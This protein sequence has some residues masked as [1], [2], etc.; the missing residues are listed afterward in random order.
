VKRPADRVAGWDLL[1][2]LCAL[3]VA[4]YHLL[5]WMH[6]AELPALGTYGVYM[7]F[8][9]SGASLAYNYSARD[10][11]SLADAL[12][13]LRTRWLRLA[14]LYVLLS[15]LFLL[16]LAPRLAG[17]SWA[18]VANR[19][20]WNATFAFGLRDPATSAI[21]I[22]GWSLGIEFIYYLC[23]PALVYVVPRVRWAIA[24]W[25][26]LAVLQ[27]A[28]IRLTIGTLGWSEGVVGYHQVPAFAAYFFGGCVIGNLR[29]TQRGERAF[30]WGVVA[31]LAMALLLFAL[32]PQEPGDELLGAS[33]YLLFAACFAVVLA[34]GSIAVQ[35][36]L[37]QFSSW[38][39]DITYGT[40]LMHPMIFWTI[41]WFVLPGLTELPLPL[42][43]L[44]LLAVVSSAAILA[45]CSERWFER[46]LRRLGRGRS[47]YIE[48]A[49]ISS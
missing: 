31:W 16:M 42:R 19:L 43:V 9:L 44:I 10:F 39:G 14:P 3:T 45:Y 26:L 32:M 28:W 2:G 36:R 21:L 34:S 17:W 49:S 1:R 27:F 20:A 48:A 7:F 24:V 12:R 46:P 18:D 11:T 13:F 22:G 5:Y 33:G 41:A 37:A 40:Y 4:T 38:M 29:R 15:L 8:V 47:R 25:L 30:A 35:G 6:I 23:F